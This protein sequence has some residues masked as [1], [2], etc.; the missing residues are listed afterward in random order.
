MQEHDKP[1]KVENART[2]T[3]LGSGGGSF[4]PAAVIFSRAAADLNKSKTSSIKPEHKDH[5]VSEIANYSSS[6]REA[7]LKV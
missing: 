5:F 2:T 6:A 4:G 1:I 3:H 7:T